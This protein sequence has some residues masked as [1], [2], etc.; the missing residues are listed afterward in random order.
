MI[1]A[2][3]LLRGRSRY[4]LAALD[5][6][7]PLAVQEQ[8]LK[9]LLNRA[10]D[11]RF[12]RDHGFAGISSMDEFRE[13]VPLRHYEDFWKEYWKPGFPVVRNATW[14]GTVPYFAKSSGTT[15]GSSKYIPVTH[16]VLGAYRRAILDMMA[17]HLRARP[18]SRVL[19]G[20]NFMLGGSIELDELATGI[21]AGDMSGISAREVPRWARPFYFPKAEVADI[22]DWERKMDVL[23]PL[24]LKEDIRTIGGTASWL[25]FFLQRLTQEQGRSLRDCYPNLELIVY[26]GVNFAPYRA[27]YEE[28]VGASGIDLREVYPASEGFIAVA[29]REPGEGMRLLTDSGTFFEFVPA[30]ELNAEKPPRYWLG[31]VEKG[32]NYAVVMNTPGGAWGYIL[33]DTVRFVDLDPPRLVVTG[34]TASSL[35][36]FGEHVIEE[37]LVRAV[38]AAADAVGS[39]V[40]DFTVGPVYP[41]GEDRRGFHRYVVEF[42]TDRVEPEKLRRFAEQLD[43]TLRHLNEDY[44]SHRQSDLQM[45][46][47][48]VMAAPPGTFAAWMKSRGKLGGQ[49]KVPRVLHD[50]ETLAGLCATAAGF[51]TGSRGRT[52]T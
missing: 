35:S 48:E 40:A 51:G 50:P 24:S 46:P 1:D 32:V 7:D 25:L 15:S 10:R 30:D 20:K 44:D 27:Q 9:S 28:L 42:D 26:G 23:G 5:R 33:G 29:D 37:E 47:P 39:A 6:Q 2:T 17:Y 13:R 3:P 4:R 34:R 45:K 38:S 11:T 22:A 21:Y 49:N 12:G 41:D 36:A 18:R 8:Q 43:G 19:G 14:P 16:E 31:N 52:T